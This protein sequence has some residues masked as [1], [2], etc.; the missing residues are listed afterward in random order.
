MCPCWGNYFKFLVFRELVTGCLIR[1]KPNLKPL[2]EYGNTRCFL[3]DTSDQL[4]RDAE[5]A[6]GKCAPKVKAEVKVKVNFTLERAT[7]AQKG[8]RCIALLFF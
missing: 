8:S 1:A 6:M 4:S 7:K 5:G 2:L 3:C